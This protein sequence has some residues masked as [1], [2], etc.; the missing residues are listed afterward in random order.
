[1]F[2]DCVNLRTLKFTYFIITNSTS[3]TDM[4]KNLSSTAKDCT[5]TMLEKAYL[6]VRSQLSAPY[7]KV[8]IWTGN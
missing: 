2:A 6:C 8:N 5:V 1:M 4:F 3:R 7:I